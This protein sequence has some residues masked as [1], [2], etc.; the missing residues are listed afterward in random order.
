MED[1]L[2]KPYL[3]ITT[4]ASQIKTHLLGKTIRVY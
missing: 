1:D 2:I 3:F 4:D